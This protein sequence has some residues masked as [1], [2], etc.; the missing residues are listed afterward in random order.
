MDI[1]Y[2]VMAIV[3]GVLVGLGIARLV[4]VG[5]NAAAERAAEAEAAR[6]VAAAEAEVEEIKKAAQVEGKELAFKL[7]ADVEE[8]VRRRKSEMAKQEE[9]LSAREGDLTRQRK[10]ATRREGELDKRERSIEGRE[11]AAEAMA[12]KAEAAQTRAQQELEE[13]SG[14]SA[15]QARARLEDSI[16]DQARE[17]AAVEVKQIEEEAAKEAAARSKEIVATAIQRYASE[18][19]Q[20]RT[21]SVV[22]LPSDDMKGRLI[23]REGRNIRALEAATGI[24]MIIDDTSEVITISCFNPVRREIA[25]L[26]ISKLVADGRIHPT[27]IEEVVQKATTEID[28]VCKEAGEQ[29]VFDLGLHR[30]HPD[31]VMQLGRLKY[32][33]SYAQNLLQHSIEVGFLAGLMASEVGLSVK[34]ARRA[35]LLHDIGKSIDHELEGS[36]AQVGAQMARKLGESPKVCQAIAAHHGEPGPQSVLDHIVDAA[37]QLSAARPGARRELLASYVARLEDLEKICASF[38]GVTKAFALQAGRE[39]RV[40]VENHELDDAQALML[41]KDIARRIENE[42]TYA[43]QVRVVVVRETRASDYAR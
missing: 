17:A 11:K 27:R 14:L 10:D 9:S 18:F 21:V 7:K 26:A 4:G 8:E 34:Q 19:V 20:E 37:N 31:L 43:G 41:S 33:S 29:A 6:I 5:R 1:I 22:P 28:K 38:A 13:I 40:M 42:A 36:H 25:R 32:R 3:A 2:V 15:E 30:V 23:G 16:R 12:R 39:V 35:G 24:D